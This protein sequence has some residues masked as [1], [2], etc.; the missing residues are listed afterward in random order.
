MYLLLFLCGRNGF[1]KVLPSIRE[2]ARWHSGQGTT[3]Q[4]GRSRVRFPM[5]SLDFFSDITLP[6]DSA[7][8]RNEY[9]VYFLGVKAAGAK[10]WPYHHPVPLSWNLGTL[11]FV[12]PSGPLQTCN[13]TALPLPFGKVFFVLFT[14]SLIP[15]GVCIHEWKVFFC[16]LHFVQWRR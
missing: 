15:S 3:L 1:K 9:Q 7:S 4:T 12:E 10:G 8:N 14:K 6:V 2:G 11:K 5:V 16:V 13:G